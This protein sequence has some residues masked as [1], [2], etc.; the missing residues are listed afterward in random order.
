M[1]DADEIQHDLESNRRLEVHLI[2]DHLQR[3]REGDP[4][5]VEDLIIQVRHSFSTDGLI[6]CA[7]SAAFNGW[8]ELCCQLLKNKR[9]ADWGLLNDTLSAVVEGA[10]AGG[11]FTSVNNAVKFLDTIKKPADRAWF[12]AC[13]DGFHEEGG[14]ERLALLPLLPVRALW[15]KFYSDFMV[16]PEGIMA[17]KENFTA[18]CWWFHRINK[19]PL[20]TDLVYLIARRYLAPGLSQED[21]VRINEAVN[22]ICPRAQAVVEEQHQ[23]Q[24]AKILLWNQPRRFKKTH[25]KVALLLAAS[26][27]TAEDFAAG[28][29]SL[30]ERTLALCT[31]RFRP[32]IDSLLPTTMQEFMKM[33]PIYRNLTAMKVALQ[34]LYE[35]MNLNPR[36]DNCKRFQ[37]MLDDLNQDPQFKNESS[38]PRVLADALSKHRVIR[39]ERRRWISRAVISMSENPDLESYLYSAVPPQVRAHFYA[40]FPEVEA[41]LY[42]RKQAGM[43]R[44]EMN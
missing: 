12:A 40:L 35:Y 29:N 22:V 34:N 24:A 28:K 4:E 44:R 10:C 18:L 31:H 41:I 16:S 1:L 14:P 17:W 9:I 33:H 21:A 39:Y 27:L 19:A 38:N 5:M 15:R 37:L 8:G 3:A 36:D 7:Q 20:S 32:G 6:V 13:M 2:T 25:Q 26:Q 42:E 23:W 43:V 11:H 30:T